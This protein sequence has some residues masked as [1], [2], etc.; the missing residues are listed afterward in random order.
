MTTR[1]T[2]TLSGNTSFVN[3]VNF[4]SDLDI[5]GGCVIYIHYNSFLYTN[6]TVTFNN[7]TGQ[8]G[9]GII[10]VESSY[11][12]FNGITKF[13]NNYAAD[14]GGAIH[15]YQYDAG[16]LGNNSIHFQGLTIFANNSAIRGGA[17]YCQG[18]NI[19]ISFTGKTIFTNNRAKLIGAHLTFY[20]CKSCIAD[21]SGNT[22]VEKGQSPMALGVIIIITGNTS[23]AFNGVNIFTQNSAILHAGNI[24]AVQG[25][26]FQCHGNN[27]FIGN[28]GGVFVFQNNTF[29]ISG[30]TL[31]SK[32]FNPTGFGAGAIFV[33]SG[34][35]ILQ[36]YIKFVNN[37]ASKSLLGIVGIVSSRVTLKGKIYF[38]SNS[39][40]DG[41]AL[42][43][44]LNSYV[45]FIGNVMLALNRAERDGGAIIC[46][47]SSMLLQGFSI[48]ERNEAKDGYGGAVHAV[49]CKIVVKG[50]HVFN[51]N[52][53]SYGG[54][55]SLVSDSKI[56]LLTSVKLVF[57]NNSADFGGAMYIEDTMS[58]T[59][60]MDDTK[61]LTNSSFV[62]RSECFFDTN[63]ESSE[64][65]AVGNYANNQGNF[66][67]GGMLNQCTV[68]KKSGD[69]T[70]LR[71]F[72]NSLVS[73]GASFLITSQPYRLCFCNSHDNT[74][75]CETELLH[76]RITRGEFFTIPVA[77]LDQLN[78]AVFSTVRAE[79]PESSNKT[80][81]FGAFDNIQSTNAVC[82]EL[83]YRIFSVSETEDIVIYA[84]GPCMW[85][86]WKCKSYN[87][88]HICSMS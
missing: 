51:N 79:L 55:L 54:V 57:I 29:V 58:P 85:K 69:K 87:F 10:S 39:A 7:N 66:L 4:G 81:R 40:N 12:E 33:L 80:S 5:V 28:D 74:P 59:D 6:A 38:L 56:T 65:K 14:A 18:E 50:M 61:L 36:G 15:I 22:T 1:S 49:D 75:N 2:L 78:H 9:S 16:P 62:L 52:K 70:F 37:I 11:L 73:A 17:I 24:Q 32:N 83:K 20:Y 13:M 30:A 86:D 8:S 63:T 68:N 45:N 3:N 21:F 60:C 82:T 72:D 67:L 34:S 76:V 53:A 44:S 35:G 71:L 27:I 84:E 23:M 43:V 41:A 77:A 25:A 19:S 31:Y 47:R 64:I 48:F 42:S 26:K 46:T 88:Y